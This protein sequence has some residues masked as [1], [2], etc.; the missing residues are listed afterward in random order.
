[1]LQFKFDFDIYEAMIGLAKI[2]PKQKTCACKMY[3]GALVA[4]LPLLATRKRLR[5]RNGDLA[6]GASHS[7]TPLES[8]YSKRHPHSGL[9]GMEKD[10]PEAEPPRQRNGFVGMLYG[11]FTDTLDD[12][13]RYS[14]SLTESALT[15]QRI[16]S[17]PGR[18]K[19]VF[20]LTDCVGCRAYRGSDSADVGAYFTAYFYPFK[21]RWMS[22]GVARQRVEQCFRVALV[23]DPRTNLLEAERWACAIRDASVQQAP[24]KDGVTNSEVRRPC[25]V[26][27]LV[28]PLSGRGQALQLFTG[29]LQGMLTEAA[30]PYTLVITEHQNHARELVK[31]A[32]LSQ[33]DALVIMSGDGLLFEVINGLMER[34]DWQE[35]IQTPL[36][37]LP[38]GS[39]NALA[40]SV[41][42]YSQ[43]PPAWN[44]E[45]L[46]SCGFMLC[47]GLV[48]SLDLVSI[49]LASKQRIFSFLS[50]AWG[51]VAD[52]DIESEKY[53]HVGAIRFLMGTLVRLATLRV[54]QGRLAYLPVKEKPS[55]SPAPQ[56]P[57]LCSSLPCQ[58]IPNS[59]PTH[60]PHRHRNNT[61]STQNTVS[62]SSVHAKRLKT[63]N[64]GKTRAPPDSLLPG[65][66]QPVPE[67]WTVVKTEDFVLVLAIYQS[68]LAED[69]WAVP[70]AAADDGIIHLFYVTGGISRPALLRLFLAM[71]KG[72]HLACGCPH[73]VY[74]KVRALRLE[75]IS[76]QGVITVD[77]ETVEYGPVQA[78]IHPGLA[79]LIYG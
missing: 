2:G 22:A 11:E 51:F 6:L 33:W 32:D 17:S 73:L 71:E 9:A 21:R 29:H 49:H 1:M 24:R 42:H 41:H 38:G 72:A 75:P 53:R 52:V 46:L 54:Y 62:S 59:S 4:A 55:L 57:S 19:V 8:R 27:I 76:R 15:I 25:R 7:R 47:K 20:N 31:K 74:E 28:N 77:G 18:T 69:L 63:P 56:R 12:K 66:D 5:T 26:M 37:I 30:I 68:H 50:L 43:S 45:L 60:K 13:V 10:A 23:Q 58:L 64:D 39:G 70:G 3:L 61:N 14:V 67:S 16:S 40:A 48:G 44:E 65:L 78:Q 35:A 34:D 79:R 36:G